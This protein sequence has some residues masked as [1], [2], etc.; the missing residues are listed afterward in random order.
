M[1][2]WATTEDKPDERFLLIR[3]MGFYGSGTILHI[4]RTEGLNV[5]DR[6]SKK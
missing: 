5:F 6:I 4:S 1:G 3:K 2:E